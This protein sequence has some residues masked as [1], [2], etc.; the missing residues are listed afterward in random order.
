M[1]T[2]FNIYFQLERCE[3]NHGNQRNSSIKRENENMKRKICLL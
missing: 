3:S 2:Y 1:K